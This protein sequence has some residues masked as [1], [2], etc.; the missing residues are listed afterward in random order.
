MQIET[1]LT[2]GGN[3]EEALSFYKR[4]LGGEITGLMRYE[5]SPMDNAQLPPDWKKKVMHSTFETQGARLMAS[6]GMPGQPKPSYQGFSI[7]L[8]VPGD[9][10]NARKA[11]DALAEG[12]KVTMPFAPPFWGGHFGMLTDRFGIPWMVSSEH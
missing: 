1:Y 12:G 3:C 7:S 6:D 9:A 11:F 10:E 8:F 2:F 5:G 4:C